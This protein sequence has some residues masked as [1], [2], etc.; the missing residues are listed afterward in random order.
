MFERLLKSLLFIFTS[1]Q[2]LL[3]LFESSNACERVFVNLFSASCHKIEEKKNYFWKGKIVLSSDARC[4][5]FICFLAL[6]PSC[7]MALIVSFFNQKNAH[8]I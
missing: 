6:K 3:A 1:S 7:E 4:S 2:F 5:F 8:V